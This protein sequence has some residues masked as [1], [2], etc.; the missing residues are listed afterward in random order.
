VSGVGWAFTC[1]KQRAR[2]AKGCRAHSHRLDSPDKYVDLL[3]EMCIGIQV[4]GES[5]QS[6]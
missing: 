2:I 6:A 3:A 1:P 4:F 5:N